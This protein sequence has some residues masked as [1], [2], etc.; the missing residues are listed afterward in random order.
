MHCRTGSYTVEFTASFARDHRP[1]AQ[2]GASHPRRCRASISSLITRGSKA[3]PPS[4]QVSGADM[5]TYALELTDVEATCLVSP[6]SPARSRTS[7]RGA[8]ELHHLRTVWALFSGLT[9]R[10]RATRSRVQR[11]RRG[12]SEL[13][14]AG[15]ALQ[16]HVRGDLRTSSSASRSHLRLHDRVG[17]TSPRRRCP[18]FRHEPANDARL[19]FD[20]LLNNVIASG[21]RDHPAIIHKILNEI[22]HSWIFE[23]KSEFGPEMEAEVMKL[24]R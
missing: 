20:Q 18:T 19:D 11:R 13:L 15:R 23:I 12:G 17:S 14:E 9:P 24:T 21:S 7:V 16:P 8:T 22:L 10:R 2:Y 5:R 1:A 4:A 3:R 6:R